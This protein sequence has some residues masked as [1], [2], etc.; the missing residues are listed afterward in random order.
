MDDIIINNII[1]ELKNNEDTFDNEYIRLKEKYLKELDSLDRILNKE[2]YD[3]LLKIEALFNKI[4]DIEIKHVC[5]QMLKVVQ[6]KKSA[7]S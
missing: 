6:N 2:Q 3:K 5:K 4:K 7:L 1:D